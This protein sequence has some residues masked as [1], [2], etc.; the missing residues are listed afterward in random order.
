MSSNPQQ[1]LL[2]QTCVFETSRTGTSSRLSTPVAE[3]STAA[4]SVR[5]AIALCAVISAS[6][7]HASETASP[8]LAAAEHSTDSPELADRGEFGLD[9]MGTPPDVGEDAV[10][11][12]QMVNAP[13]EAPLVLSASDAERVL[14]LLEAPPNPSPALLALFRDA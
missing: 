11:L 8:W 9:E 12:D 1:N 2:R 5:I 13:L 7:V 4:G 3:T 10:D 14:A 6:D